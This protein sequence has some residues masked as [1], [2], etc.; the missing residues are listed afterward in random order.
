MNQVISKASTISPILDHGEKVI[1]AHGQMLAQQYAKSDTFYLILEGEV[2]FSLH[3][4]GEGEELI[5]GYSNEDLT[6]VGWSGFNLPY[7]YTTTVRVSSKQAT[8][9]R[10]E[11]EQL[12]EFLRK[13]PRECESFL[14]LVCA[15]SGNLIREA[16]RLLGRYAP[17][18]P[19][20]AAPGRQEEFQRI[21]H[22]QEDLIQFLRRSP[23][24]E[25]FDEGPLAYISQCIQQR[26]Y[27][28]ND[29][30]YEQ[31][32]KADGI[33]ILAIGK[34]RFSYHD[35]V[36]LQFISFR[37]LTTPGFIVGWAGGIE[38]SN[39]I[40]AHA[41]QESLIYFIPRKCLEALKEK[42][43]TFGQKL[44]YRLLWLINHQ[45]Q[46]VRARLIL[47]KFNHEIVAISNL[48]EQNSTR[49]ELTSSLHKVPHLL[50][51]KLTVKDG[52]E[53]L[54]LLKATGS[55]L[56]KNIAALSLDILEEINR[57]Q[58]F[59]SGLVGVYEKVV[60][61][62]ETSTPEELR[63]KSAFAYA[64]LFEDISCHISGWEN[65]PDTPGNIFIYNHLR[66][67]PFNT[68]P[69]Q[70]QL[71]LDSHFISALILNKKYEDPGIRIVRIGRGAEY[72]H[73]EYYQRLGHI[74]VYTNESDPDK[75][76]SEQRDAQRKLFYQKAG[77]HLSDGK[78][79]IISPEGTSFGTEESPGPF[80]SGA[81]RL[82][83]SLPKEPLFVPVALANFDKRIRNNCF[84]C[85]ILPPFKVSDYLSDP[86]D[87]SAM[88]S[89]LTHYQS[90]F[91]GYVEEALS[92][93]TGQVN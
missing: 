58:Q 88:K 71:T 1:L 37:Q 68:L 74:D 69:N 15:K 80:K 48:I 23:F 9:Y 63:K 47:A 89:F 11:H 21:N 27:R 70:F 28:T 83:L 62:P 45:L 60:K 64:R 82:A 8:A 78:N 90:T 59:Y 41:V 10:W 46:A 39:L 34:I 13:H 53:T 17:A 50:E 86:S 19:Q 30:V 18:L 93:A 61:A 75:A 24:F 42:D 32:S 85:I 52:I 2:C 26:Q 7:R 66:N 77:T 73:Q 38:L 72:A 65:L 91:K 6:P 55:S 57:E 87:K 33:Y 43:P 22:P 79:L 25:V 44:H 49:L 3:L 54:K 12:S 20:P 14:K 36:N 92:L 76:N 40:S 81:F 4:E 16:I 67:H 56:E 35:E 84:S 51:N 5:V 31:G 29:T